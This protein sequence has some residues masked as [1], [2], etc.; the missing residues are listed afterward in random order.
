MQSK[1]AGILL[2]IVFSVIL[3]VFIANQQFKQNSNPQNSTVVI[4]TAQG[5]EPSEITVAVGATITFLNQDKE[6]RW[7]ASNLHPTHLIY[8]EF[9][10]K[11][12]VDPDKSWSFKFDKVGTW[13]YHDHLA[14]KFTGK[15]TTTSEPNQSIT[16]SSKSNFDLPK[17]NEITDK[18]DQIA[19]NKGS[20]SAWNYFKDTYPNANFNG[21]HNIA[22]YIGFLIYEEIGLDGLKQCDASFA[23]GCYHG[24]IEEFINQENGVKNLDSVVR[25][26]QQ[27]PLQSQIPCYHGIGHGILPYFKYNLSQTLPFCDSLLSSDNR[28]NCYNGVFM[29]NAL[30]KGSQI[31]ASNPLWPCNTVAD[32]YKSSCYDYQMVLLSQSNLYKNDIAQIAQICS[33]AETNEYTNRCI[34]G[35]G[36]YIAQFN[37]QSPEKIVQDCNKIKGDNVYVCQI[38][39]AEKL[40]FLRRSYDTVK[41][42]LCNPLPSSWESDCL[43]RINLQREHQ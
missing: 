37:S 39:A 20:L 18:V 17:I 43:N 15:V 27:I 11:E 28:V 38:A 5:F 36:Q 40:I 24:F 9:D 3:V 25:V 41:T 22:H 21:S 8:P 14:P 2:I 42:K 30:A 16:Q 19:K 12:P 1:M 10:P 6:A 34:R 35:L 29:E 31:T 33:Q 26:C 4:I 23:F 7:P 32:K 13:K